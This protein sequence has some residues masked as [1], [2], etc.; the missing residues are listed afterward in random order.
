MMM[1]MNAGFS[2]FKHACGTT[3]KDKH[4]DKQMTKASAFRS[5]T[6]ESWR[7]GQSSP[8]CSTH[9]MT[10]TKN[11]TL[12]VTAKP[13]RL[14]LRVRHKL[15]ISFLQPKP[16]PHPQISWQFPCP[17]EDTHYHVNLWINSGGVNPITFTVNIK[18][19]IKKVKKKK[20]YRY[21]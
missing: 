4:T 9:A 20:I 10:K 7:F 1:V 6:K 19:I 14:S 13:R 21:H 5:H 16:P 12:F 15:K 2:P 11:T 18:S 3:R 17:W 8:S